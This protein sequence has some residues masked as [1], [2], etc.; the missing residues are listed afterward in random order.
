MS[1][2]LVSFLVV[3]GLGYLILQI[4]AWLFIFVMFAI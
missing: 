2:N 4:L 3:I 1:F